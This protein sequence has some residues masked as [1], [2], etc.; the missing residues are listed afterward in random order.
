MT[1][2]D[3]RHLVEPIQTLQDRVASRPSS[4]PIDLTTQYLGN[5]VVSRFFPEHYA[6]V[7]IARRTLERYRDPS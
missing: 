3:V 7:Q 4:I 1:V 2:D 5:R 6:R